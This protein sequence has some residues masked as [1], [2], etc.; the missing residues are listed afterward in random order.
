M[1]MVTLRGSSMFVAGCDI[2]RY[3]SVKVDDES[4]AIISCDDDDPNRV[5]V[6]LDDVVACHVVPVAT[7][8]ITANVELD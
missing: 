2:T 6:T 1:L 5:G 4:G 8:Q 7:Y 3:S